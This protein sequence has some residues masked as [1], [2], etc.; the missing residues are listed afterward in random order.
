MDE[1]AD[2]E[3]RGKT[4]SPKPLLQILLF[5]NGDSEADAHSEN[6]PVGDR[7]GIEA[8]EIDRECNS[9]GDAGKKAKEI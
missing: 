4:N 1:G 9:A 7:P 5:N 3:R 8:I 2:D 6:C